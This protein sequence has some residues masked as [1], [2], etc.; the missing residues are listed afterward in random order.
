MNPKIF[1]DYAQRT[2]E[3]RCLGVPCGTNT[4]LVGVE[5][6]RYTSCIHREAFE[7]GWEAR[8]ALGDPP[9]V[10]VEIQCGYCGGVGGECKRPDSCVWKFDEGTKRISPQREGGA[11]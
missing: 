4:T 9:E 10:T 11:S 5:C 1:W 2:G 3:F 7:A 6:P 8:K